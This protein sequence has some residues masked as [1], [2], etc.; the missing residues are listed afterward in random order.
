[1]VW[2]RA[3]RRGR[4]TKPESAADSRHLS[5]QAFHHAVQLE[6]EKKTQIRISLRNLDAFW[7]N[8]QGRL[9]LPLVSVS[10]FL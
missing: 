7:E 8:K 1:M 5:C 3:E 4:G 9:P 6:N 10:L 2:H